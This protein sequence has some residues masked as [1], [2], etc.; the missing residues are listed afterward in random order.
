MFDNTIGI[1]SNLVQGHK[2]KLPLI[3][4]EIDYLTDLLDLVCLE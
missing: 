1:H 3:Q 4:T 2:S